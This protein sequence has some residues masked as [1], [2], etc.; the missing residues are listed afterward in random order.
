MT[1]NKV[2]QKMYHALQYK[3]HEKGKQTFL[4]SPGS[5]LI[6][7]DNTNIR[8]SHVLTIT[9]NIFRYIFTLFLALLWEG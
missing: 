5:P 9:F 6:N 1:S 3:Q 2:S 4:R 8:E 7:S